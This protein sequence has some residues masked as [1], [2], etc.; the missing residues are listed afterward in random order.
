MWIYSKDP[1]LITWQ[2][3][4]YLIY[5]AKEGECPAVS[6]GGV[7]ICIQE[8]SNDQE[9]P[10]AKKCCSNGCGHIC[11]DPVPPVGTSHF[12]VTLYS[13]VYTESS[14]AMFFSNHFF[15]MN[16]LCTFTLE[17]LFFS[18]IMSQWIP[19]VHC[20]EERMN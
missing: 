17:T 15:K 4:L 16:I 13:S 12:W 14:H 19:E 3:C 1:H 6:S 20:T 5:T 2:F 8:C 11:V 7:G 10:D 18:W 9:C